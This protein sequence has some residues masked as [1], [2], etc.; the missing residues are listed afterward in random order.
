MERV[1]CGG[2]G[3]VFVLTRFI[4]KASARANRE[5]PWRMAKIPEFSGAPGPCGT[6]GFSA[7][8]LVAGGRH[9]LASVKVESEKLAGGD[10]EN[11]G[12]LA[13]DDERVARVGVGDGVEGAALGVC[14]GDD[15]VAHRSK[16]VAGH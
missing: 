14:D 12:E 1:R 5:S 2:Q 13:L 8:D 7:S 9:K 11:V 4:L 10:R 16:I 6:R 15:V 3:V